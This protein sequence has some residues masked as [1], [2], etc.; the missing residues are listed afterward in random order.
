[1]TTINIISQIN[2]FFPIDYIELNDLYSMIDALSIKTIELKQQSRKMNEKD[3]ASIENWATLARQDRLDEILLTSPESKTAL[4][5]AIHSYLTG[6]LQKRVGTDE[7]GYQLLHQSTFYYL[8]LFQDYFPMIDRSKA[9]NIT[10]LIKNKK[11]FIDYCFALDIF[12]RN[13]T[14]KTIES[15]YDTKFM[16]YLNQFI[17]AMEQMLECNIIAISP[18]MFQQKSSTIFKSSL[19]ERQFLTERPTYI[20]YFENESWYSVIYVNAKEEKSYDE[21]KTKFSDMRLKKLI[22][23]EHEKED[24]ENLIIQYEPTDIG[25]ELPRIRIVLEKKEITLLVGCTNNLYLYKSGDTIKETTEI[26]GKIDVI[27]IDKQNGKGNI[28]WVAGFQDILG[29]QLF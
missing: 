14:V 24:L 2:N 29:I 12:D 18:Q 6:V 7:D 8:Y 9:W 17:Y 22:H 15:K 25:K 27:S 1:M 21:L 13:D 16:Y 3:K 23:V 26:V 10:E 4:A 5:E 11:E 20:L 19:T 28:R